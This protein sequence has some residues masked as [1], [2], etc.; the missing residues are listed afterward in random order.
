MK[1][2]GIKLMALVIAATAIVFIWS[3]TQHKSSD[4]EQDTWVGESGHLHVLGIELGRSTLRETEVALKSRSDIALYIYPKEH[5]EAGLRLEAYFPSIADHSKVIA[6]LDA[7]PEILEQLQ[8]RAT[9]PHLYPNKV[10]RM[11]LHPEDIGTVQQLVVK[12]VTL[13]PSIQI[14]EQMLTNRF[15]VPSSIVRGE[16]EAAAD[17]YYFDAIGLHATL[18]AEDAARLEFQNPSV[19]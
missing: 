7:S 2:M 6:E 5:P 10:A 16:G 3:A 14:T 8:L 13:I 15:G 17:H 19:K 12:K 18:A 4:S 11:N 9:I 1:Y